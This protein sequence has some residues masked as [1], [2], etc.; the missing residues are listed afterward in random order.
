MDYK[1]C[2]TN[3]S[4]TTELMPAA[5]GSDIPR[6]LFSCSNDYCGAEVSYYA[7]QLYWYADEKRWV[8]EFCWDN[9]PGPT[10]ED[11]RPTR[12]VTLAEHIIGAAFSAVVLLKNN[13]VCET[14][15]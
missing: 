8:C 10:D 15:R 12:G 6:A 14:R 4:E 11:G 9:L 5:D 7:D 13:H 2:M 3:Q 1:V